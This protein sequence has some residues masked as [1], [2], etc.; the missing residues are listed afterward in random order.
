ME[1]AL[2]EVRRVNELLLRLL[3]EL[4]ALVAEREN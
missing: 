4:E 2:K 3:R 1:E